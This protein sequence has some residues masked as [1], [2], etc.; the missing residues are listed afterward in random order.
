MT[1]PR[2]PQLS[3][4]LLSAYLDNEVTDEERALI[5]RTIATDPAVAW[6]V[7]SLRQTVTLLQALPPLALP[8]SF[9]IDAGM[10]KAPAITPVVIPAAVPK[11]I[12]VPAR[13]PIYAIQA[14]AENSWWQSLLQFWQGGNLYW[15]NA[16][17]VAFTVLIVLFASDQVVTP[18][19]PPGAAQANQEVAQFTVSSPAETEVANPVALKI[20]ATADEMGTLVV[21]ENAA[22]PGE[23]PDSDNNAADT[24]E[25]VT[26]NVE[27]DAA[28]VDASVADATLPPA[29]AT[30]YMPPIPQAPR[31]D[32]L[33][34]TGGGSGAAGPIAQGP[35]GQGGGSFE[36]GNPADD[37]R[38]G[39]VQSSQAGNP[40]P[41]A[42][43]IE[44]PIA[45]PA[46]SAESVARAM[47]TADL[48]TPT[49]E[50]EAVSAA[51]ISMT[52]FATVTQAVTVSETVTENV[53]ETVSATVTPLV[54]QPT[55]I[56][57]T[58]AT[59]AAA[60][61]IMNDPQRWLGWAQLVSVLFTVVLGTLWWRSRG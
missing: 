7:E 26:E 25:I 14:K 19:V 31:E 60:S 34:V 29:S 9:A 21:P 39:M 20:A 42:S 32:T 50:L 13:Q 45:T 59:M 18:Y 8:R 1:L 52:E 2:H 61:P 47:V 17:A 49:T 30:A 16:A 27:Q 48:A 56:L 24:A 22:A 12:A 53:T 10:A 11:P 3:E 43:P 15:R 33:D 38:L 58:E 55:A 57:A 4:E 46:D 36:S 35:P 28:A 5:E 37:P 23:S 44:Q 51:K 6:Q 40:V 41:A 54:A